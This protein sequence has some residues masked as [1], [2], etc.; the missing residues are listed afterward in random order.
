M[1]FLICAWL[2]RGNRKPENQFDGFRAGPEFLELQDYDALEWAFLYS[3]RAANAFASS[4]ELMK[5]V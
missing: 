2:A 3:A 1:L 5:K 4:A